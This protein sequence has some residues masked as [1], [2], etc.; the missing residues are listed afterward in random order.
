LKTAHKSRSSCHRGN[1]AYTCKVWIWSA[2]WKLEDSQSSSYGVVCLHWT[3]LVHFYT[4]WF[5]ML[6]KCGMTIRTPGISTQ[7][8][9][10]HWLTSAK[11]HTPPLL[12]LLKFWTL[13][14][15]VPLIY[16]SSQ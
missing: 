4:S 1:A 13:I 16:C 11:N 2:P 14:R 6:R 15:L 3:S 10:H 8:N 12:T 5:L 7:S 9:R